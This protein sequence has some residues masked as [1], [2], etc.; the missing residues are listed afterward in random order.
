MREVEIAPGVASAGEPDDAE[1]VVRVSRL[2]F[3]VNAYDIDPMA[4]AGNGM[5]REAAA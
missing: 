3:R 1:P 2:Q 5:N 4:G